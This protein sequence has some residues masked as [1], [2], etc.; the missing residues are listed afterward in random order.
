[1][2]W[3]LPGVKRIA[4]SFVLL[5][6]ILN[7]LNHAGVEFFAAIEAARQRSGMLRPLLREAIGR[8][9]LHPVDF[10]GIYS[11]TFLRAAILILAE[12]GDPEVVALFER[13]FREEAGS[14][15]LVDPDDPDLEELA[16]L[17]APVFA[18]VG[19]AAVTPHLDSPHLRDSFH[20]V[21]LGA[22]ALASIWNP[23]ARLQAIALYHQRLK[24]PAWM[25]WSEEARDFFV[26]ICGNTDPEDFAFPLHLA[27]QHG[28]VSQRAVDSF[29]ESRDAGMSG[30]AN[31]FSSTLSIAKDPSFWEPHIRSLR[32]HE[33]GAR[34][35]ELPAL[36][37]FNSLAAPSRLAGQ[38]LREL[39]VTSELVSVSANVLELA[40][41]NNTAGPWGTCE[42]LA[43]CIGAPTGSSAVAE[44]IV[45]L[46]RMSD[47]A[48][49]SVLGDDLT[50][51]VPAALPLC[52]RDNVPLLK[53][54]VE[55]PEVEGSCRA[56]ALEAIYVLTQW[57]EYPAAEL[58]DYLRGLV[59]RSESIGRDDWLWCE[60]IKTLLKLGERD[61]VPTL[62]EMVVSGW[63]WHWMEAGEIDGIHETPPVP[64]RLDRCGLASRSGALRDATSS[65]RSRAYR[66]RSR[67]VGV[68]GEERCDS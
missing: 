61:L 35:E 39:V 67:S 63:A 4:S 31:L 54:L 51:L 59:G 57:H 19:I 37:I 56:I 20:S 65:A 3:G 15:L 8:M 6:D 12:S 38:R 53:G 32:P 41:R 5:I 64:E 17:V 47:E 30:W 62:R 40:A 10:G 29:F 26:E 36:E 48:L 22:L 68:D 42:A 28:L 13:Y 21:L 7:G 23:T 58:H 50:E 45:R 2:S 52:C 44:G 11:N 43:I 34:G 46:L 49:R 66:Q 14:K 16:C 1:M 55:D 33:I 24:L 60:A 18:T 27:A 9:S 25:G